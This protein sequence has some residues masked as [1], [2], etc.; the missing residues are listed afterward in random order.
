MQVKCNGASTEGCRWGCRA[1]DGHELVVLGQKRWGFY[2]REGAIVEVSRMWP[3][4]CQQRRSGWH[5]RSVAQLS[6]D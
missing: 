4:I 5:K 6:T 3:R 1:G 2:T